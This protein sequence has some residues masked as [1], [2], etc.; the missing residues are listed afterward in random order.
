VQ[1]EHVAGVRLAARRAAQQQRDGAVGLGLLRQVV[2]DDQDVLAAVHPVLADGRAGVGREV[3][4][5]R[6]VG[7]RGRDDRGVLHRAGVLERA[8]DGR[9]RGALLA[10]GDV[11]AA[12]C[13]FVSPD[14]QLAFWLMIVSIAIA[15]LPVWR[16]PMMSWRWPRPIGIIASMA[17]MPVC[18]GS[19]TDLRCMTPGAWQLE[20]AAALDAGDLAEAVD[21]V[22]ERVDDA[23]EVALADGSGEDLARCG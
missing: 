4:E 1:V 18:S 6:G 19:C 14:S 16:S 2:E 10:D 7:G 23:A 3:L 5:A 20:G 11:D 17:L 8:L 21:R 13:L 15:V 9:D 12:T 22:A